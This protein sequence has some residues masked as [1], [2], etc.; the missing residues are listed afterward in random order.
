MVVLYIR[1]GPAFSY[2]RR[3]SQLC[4]TQLCDLGQLTSPLWAYLF[5][6]FGL[7]AGFSLIGASGGYSLVVVLSLLIVVVSLIAEHGL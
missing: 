2:K 3:K 6:C 5:S 1:T 4:H 7:H